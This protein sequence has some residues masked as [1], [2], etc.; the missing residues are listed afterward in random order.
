VH[1]RKV[2][3]EARSVQGSYQSLVSRRSES[4]EMFSSE[5]PQSLKTK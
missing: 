4:R 5:V 2:N 1:I 3:A